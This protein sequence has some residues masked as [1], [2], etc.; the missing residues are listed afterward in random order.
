MS[1]WLSINSLL[2][3]KRGKTVDVGGLVEISGTG[4]RLYM[5]SKLP[6]GTVIPLVIQTR[7]GQI[8]KVPLKLVWM[9]KDEMGNVST[10]DA[11]IRLMQE[12]IRNDIKVE[13]ITYGYLY[14]GTFLPESDPEGIRLIERHMDDQRNPGRETYSQMQAPDV[15]LDVRSFNTTDR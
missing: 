14:G 13:G 5:T 15:S 10:F 8:L 3:K 2:E 4:A 6:V 11:R 9:K 1:G 12:L 7:K